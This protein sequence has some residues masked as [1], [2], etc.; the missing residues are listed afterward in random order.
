MPVRCSKQGVTVGDYGFGEPMIPESFPEKD[1]RNIDG[2]FGSI[3]GDKV[4]SAK[5]IGQPMF[6]LCQSLWQMEVDE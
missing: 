5:K 2:S 6:S 1:V 4:D 3:A